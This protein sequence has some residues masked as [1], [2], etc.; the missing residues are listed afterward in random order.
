[1]I[2]AIIFDLGGVLLDMSPLLDYFAEIFKIQE[3]DKSKFWHLIAIE[4]IPYCKGEMT[5]FKGWKKIAKKLGKKIPDK[6]LRNLWTERF[7]ELTHVDNEVKDI[8]ISLKKN[9]TVAAITNISEEHVKIN[10]KRGFFDIFDELI[11]SNKIGMT[12]D[13]K[14]IFEYTLKKLSCKPEECVF[15][16]DIQ[17]FVNMAE[18][19][20]MKGILFENAAQLKKDLK[21]LGVKR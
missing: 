13:D 17:E 15:V 1:M 4:F 16:D 8:I 11:L 9:Y 20:G 18:S 6:I 14:R 2:K 7:E 19:I 5:G 21:K 12:K 10:E 3:K